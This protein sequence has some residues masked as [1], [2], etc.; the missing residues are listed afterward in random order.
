LQGE[1]TFRYWGLKVYHAKLWTLPTFRAED[2]SDQPLV[3]ELE[4]L[5]DLKGQAIA[6]TSI[7][8]MRRAG[9]FTAVQA[10]RWLSDMQRLFPDIKTGDRLSGLHMP[11][12]GVRFWHNTRAL[13]AVNDPEFARLFF[14]I[15]LTPT[16]SEPQLRISLLGLS[17]TR[18][19]P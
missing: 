3:L 11:G 18:T 19:Q 14:A 1:A 16:T 6:D 17:D 5:R 12:Q 15:W 10:Q 8:E 13:G 9:R 7:Q 4:Y 2:V